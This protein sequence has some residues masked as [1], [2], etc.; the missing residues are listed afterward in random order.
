MLPDTSQIPVQGLQATKPPTREAN[1]SQR[2]QELPLFMVRFV[3]EWSTPQTWIAANWRNMVY[4]LPTAMAC[5]NTIIMN[6]LSLGYHVVAREPSKADE[7]REEVKYYTDL[8]RNIDGDDYLTHT[9]LVLQDFLDIP[10]G[11]ASEVGRLGDTSDGKTM[12]VKRMDGATLFPTLNDDFPVGQRIPELLTAPTVF[13]PR[14]AVSRMYA[15]PRPEMKR[16]GWGMAPPEKIYLAMLLLS[17]GDKY[18]AN[19]L[20]DTPE[21]GILDLGQMSRDVA[22]AWLQEWHDLLFG[23]DAFK[24]PVLYEHDGEVK[25]ISFTRNPADL[26]YDRVISKYDA[27]VAAGYGL[28]LADIGDMNIGA[29]TLA[30]SI[31]SERKT[32]R[33]GVGY[34]IMKLQAYYDRILPTYLQF[35]LINRDEEQLASKGRARLANSMAFANMVEKMGLPPEV[36]VAQLVSDGLITVPVPEKLNPVMSQLTLGGPNSPA[37]G[38]A[39]VGQTNA[40]G[41]PQTARTAINAPTKT[42]AQGGMGDVTG[43]SL[44][45]DF[46]D[47]ALKQI[48]D[49][50][51]A[52]LINLA[53]RQLEAP[54]KNAE[55][56]LDDDGFTTWRTEYAKLITGDPSQFDNLELP[57]KQL[58]AIQGVL[59]A[60]LESEPLVSVSDA[61]STQFKEVTK[62][63]YVEVV[64]AK[65]RSLSDSEYVQGRPRP[66]FGP[67]KDFH[68]DW[69]QVQ[70]VW[71]SVANDAAIALALLYA[72]RT[73]GKELPLEDAA[74]EARIEFFDA[75]SVLPDIIVED[76]QSQYERM[77][78]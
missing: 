74:T 41:D 28:T 15:T 75:M 23:P 35:E 65:R 10:F 59:R 20:L 46:V 29:N 9:E 22:K 39:G 32:A 56:A 5:R 18:Y 57:V 58:R 72:L 16:R 49:V 67:I 24:V 43:K 8:L 53:Q 31:R 50:H 25:Y 45:Q 13:F 11:G 78:L 12:W 38:G 66:A 34:T 17:R 6:I 63:E 71:Q 36:G 51:F 2:Q 61:D 76:L 30:G 27:L 21:A 64:A 60:D 52:R 77:A 33:T 37:V 4:N 48:P 40:K 26:M 44:V 68:G 55:G 1:P 70:M 42:P 73:L 69:K 14:H 47:H 7:Y 3:P 62:A 19:L 54:Y